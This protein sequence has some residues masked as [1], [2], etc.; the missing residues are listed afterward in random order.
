[1][2]FLISLKEVEKSVQVRKN[3]E[4]IEVIAEMRFL[5]SLKVV[6]NPVKAEKQRKEGKKHGVDIYS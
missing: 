5:L 1:M 2:E 3:K 6:K 4:N